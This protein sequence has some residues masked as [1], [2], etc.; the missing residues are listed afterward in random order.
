MKPLRIITDSSSDISQKEAKDLGIEVI[1]LKISFGGDTFLDGVDF[2]PDQFF[3]KLSSSI[4]LPHTSQISPQEY[5]DIF[6][7]AKNKGDRVLLL[8][9]SS[10][11]S[12]TYQSALLAKE[13][14]GYNEIYIFDTLS[15]VAG[16]RILVMEAL[17]HCKEMDIDQLIEYLTDI[18]GRIRI[19]AILD[20]L[21]YLFKGGRLSK[22]GYTIGSLLNFK[23]II[24][25][26][27]GKVELAAKERGSKKAMQTQ[28]AKMKQHVIDFSHP[29]YVVYT[30]NTGRVEEMKKLCLENGIDLTKMPL[31]SIGATIGVHIGP[32]VAGVCYVRAK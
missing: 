17:M 5:I 27:D 28:L 4:E 2:T 13:I 6:T 30:A 9:L 14:V 23:P 3:E 10:Q 18:R 21:E 24:R 31:I 25:V 26:W 1:P 8:P 15:A 22:A 20:T 29:I 7:D 11:L 12:G 19:Y 32:N 16:V